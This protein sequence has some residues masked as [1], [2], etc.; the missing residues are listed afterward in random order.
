MNRLVCF[1][2][3]ATAVLLQPGLA[4]AQSVQATPG[5][6]APTSYTPALD[7]ADGCGSGTAT[8]ATAT[9]TYSKVP[10][11]KLVYYN[12][13]IFF[14]SA[15]SGSGATCIGISIP[16]NSATVSGAQG[17]GSCLINYAQGMTL[18]TGYTS[19]VGLIGSNDVALFLYEQGSGHTTQNAPQ[20]IVGSTWGVVGQ[21]WYFSV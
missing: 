14:S 19:L 16:V 10:G 5:I 13:E 15:I 8:V 6:Y 11:T 12:F 9:A 18:D 20:T 4:L 17:A 3:A 21:C 1:L 2:I 7:Q